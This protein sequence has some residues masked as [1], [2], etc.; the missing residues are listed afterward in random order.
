METQLERTFERLKR[1]RKRA[2]ERER[3]REKGPTW[4]NR[5]IESHG[6]SSSI[7]VAERYRQLPP[8]RRYSLNYRHGN[9]RARVVI[10]P[11]I[12]E[13]PRPMKATAANPPDSQPHWCRGLFGNDLAVQRATLG[14]FISFYRTPRLQGKKKQG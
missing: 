7:V 1:E 14:R 6:V 9:E 11:A 10:E 3:E 2:R 4:G 12:D 13:A 8:V 5:L